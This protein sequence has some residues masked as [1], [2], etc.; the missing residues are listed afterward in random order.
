MERT[1]NPSRLVIA[2]QRAQLSKKDLAARVGISQKLLKL[3][4]EGDKAPSSSTVDH[5]ATALD[6]PVEFFFGRDVEVP[7]A[8]NASFRSFSRMTSGQRD[9]ALAAGGIAFELSSWIDANF[10]VPPVDVPDLAGMDPEAAAEIVR[11]QWGLGLRPIKNM[12]HLLESRGVR[13]FSLV[14]DTREVNAFSSWRG[15]R[16]PFVFLNTLKSPESSRFDAA[17]ELGHLV[18]H[19]HG[20]PKG[21]EIENE[22]NAFASAL[23]MPRSEMRALAARAISLSDVLKIK[24]HWNVSA[25]AL[26]Y[27]LHKVGVLTEW[28]Y[29]SMCIELSSKG[30]RTKEVDSADRE[31]S[32][33]LRKVFDALKQD[34]KG[35]RDISSELR[36]PAEE[37]HKL[38]F[39]LTLISLGTSNPRPAQ[40]LPKRGHL[41][42]VK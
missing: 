19:R 34:G 17:H 18:L 36:L 4:E 21:K 11:T 5:L 2:R 39:G 6:F 37:L 15:G 20:D 38:L 14:E 22:A 8:S 1:F 35:L 31:V 12:V 16:I 33:V 41:T 28:L 23:L 10:N 32:L 26:V 24:K 42:L 3:Y 25:M 9:A 13:V 27:R 40:S 30:M 29:R 7:L